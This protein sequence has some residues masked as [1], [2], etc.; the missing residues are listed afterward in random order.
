MYHLV[1]TIRPRNIQYYPINGTAL[2]IYWVPVP[3]TRDAIKGRVKGYR[4]SKS[5]LSV[6][7][8]S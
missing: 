1:P 4:V 5:Y 2:T 6:L 7:Y 3:N 8:H